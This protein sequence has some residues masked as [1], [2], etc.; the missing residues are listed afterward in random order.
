MGGPFASWCSPLPQRTSG[1]Y[2][3]PG[4]PFSELSLRTLVLLQEG[5]APYH[6]SF[7]LWRLYQRFLSLKSRGYRNR[8]TL[9]HS[10]PQECFCL[11]RFS[12]SLLCALG[13]ALF[14][15]SSWQLDSSLSSLLFSPSSFCLSRRQCLQLSPKSFFCFLCVQ[16]NRSL[17]VG[18]L[19]L[20]GLKEVRQRE[21]KRPGSF[22]SS[23]F[24]CRYWTQ[25]LS[26]LSPWI[27][28]NLLQE[29]RCSWKNRSA[30][31]LPSLTLRP[32][33][34]WQWLHYN[35]CLLTQC[36]RDRILLPS[37]SPPPKNLKY[38][39]SPRRRF[40]LNQ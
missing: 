21:L 22:V 3:L 6:F 40:S 32:L 39:C 15:F 25:N 27:S 20:W 16:E 8:W 5:I 26:R 13:L 17:M 38:L 34:F 4:K 35:A 11:M 1:G 18:N 29:G 24:R 10:I 23:S 30:R 37:L 36:T 7:L 12:F 9:L 2:S 28:L 19:S 33:K 14:A 31:L